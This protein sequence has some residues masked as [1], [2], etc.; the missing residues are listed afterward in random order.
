[1]LTAVAACGGDSTGPGPGPAAD[2]EWAAGTWVA[3]RMDG[4]PLP[5]RDATT[6]P[7]VQ[8][9]SL[10]VSVLVFGT[11]RSA[12]VYPYARTFFS[13][14]TNPTVLGCSESLGQVAI[15][16]AGLSTF[17]T[18]ATTSIG[19]CNTSWVNMTLT[20]KADSLAGTWQG[21]DVRFI[22]R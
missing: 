9:D 6:Y 11:T 10:K 7:Y 20:R 17:A 15:S 4:A 21:R 14:S 5:H 13:A 8:T 12:S 22:K 2:A 1:M 3:V 19:G 16:I 18:G